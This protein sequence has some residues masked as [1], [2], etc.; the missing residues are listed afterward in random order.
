MGNSGI[1]GFRSKGAHTLPA[2]DA[3]C[4]RN[5]NGRSGLHNVHVPFGHSD[6]FVGTGHAEAFWLPFL[7]NIDG[8]E[9]AHFLEKCKLAA[10]L[11]K[12]R[13]WQRLAVVEKALAEAHWD[14]AD[15]ETLPVLIE[16]QL[17]AE[18]G[19]PRDGGQPSGMADMVSRA[20]ANLWEVV[21][22]AVDKRR[23]ESGEHLS[24]LFPR[25]AVAKAVDAIARVSANRKRQ[26]GIEPKV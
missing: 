2:P 8:A 22:D 18:C 7:W 3:R 15:G 19:Y 13:D 11:A 10:D 23:S 21:A 24:A 9:Y 5:C 14:W 12:T 26:R 17:R 16:R 25:I 1:R 4:S 20:L 6:H